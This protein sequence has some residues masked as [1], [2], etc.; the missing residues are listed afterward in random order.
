MGIGTFFATLIVI[1]AI[2][3]V[4]VKPTY[5]EVENRELAKMP[6]FTWEGLVNGSFISDFQKYF[7]DTFLGREFL[8]EVYEMFTSNDSVPFTSF[9]IAVI[10]WSPF[11]PKSLII[12]FIEQ[13]DSLNLYVRSLPYVFTE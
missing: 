4:A 5:S 8:V 1:G 3:L 11:F 12:M 6:S 10:V 13:Q 2:N 7:S 9:V